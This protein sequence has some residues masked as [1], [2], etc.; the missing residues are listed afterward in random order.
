MMTGYM[1]GCCVF[2]RCRRSIPF[3]LPRYTS[4][5]TRSV[6]LVRRNCSASSA[7]TNAW[8]RWPSASNTVRRKVQVFTSSSTTTT[9]NGSIASAQ[10]LAYCT[11]PPIERS[12]A[13]GDY[14]GGGQGQEATEAIRFVAIMAGKSGRAKKDETGQWSEGCRQA[15]LHSP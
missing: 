7:R 3:R 12:R 2:K 5:I 11:I 10:I 1:A 15:L 9:R 14:D 4:T 6:G 13:E 8:H